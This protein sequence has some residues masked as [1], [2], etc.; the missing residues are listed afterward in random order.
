MDSLKGID[1]VLVSEMK[2]DEYFDEV[3]LEEDDLNDLEET[4]AKDSSRTRIFE[5]VKLIC[6]L[7][8]ST[9]ISKKLDSGW[10][11]RSAT[12]PLKLNEEESNF[13]ATVVNC[14]RL[15]YPRNVKGTVVC[16]SK[17]I[18]FLSLTNLCLANV[19]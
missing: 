14:L 10:I 17:A 7:V 15:Y 12:K 19:G 13:I 16:P 11:I 1:T 5:I 9:K 2:S 3:L 4:V 6:M 8:K 18:P